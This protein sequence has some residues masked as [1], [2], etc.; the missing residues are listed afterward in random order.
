MEGGGGGGVGD[1]ATKVLPMTVP[2][3]LWN[4]YDFAVGN[5]V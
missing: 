2:H 5:S 3:P 4:R 1:R